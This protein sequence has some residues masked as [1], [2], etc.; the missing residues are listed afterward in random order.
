MQSEWGHFP[1]QLVAGSLLQP[2]R[3]L[4]GRGEAT[5]RPG[6]R[7]APDLEAKGS[8]AHRYPL[9]ASEGHHQTQGGLISPKVASSRARGPWSAFSRLMQP[10]EQDAWTVPG[11]PAQVPALGLAGPQCQ[12]VV[13]TKLGSPD[14][15]LLKLGPRGHQHR[16]ARENSPE[17]RS[18]PRPPAFWLEHKPGMPG[19]HAGRSL[20]W[21]VVRDSHCA[22][23]CPG[24][25]LAQAASRSGR[26]PVRT[27]PSWTQWGKV[28]P[29]LRGMAT[30]PGSWS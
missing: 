22:Q 14:V 25:A 7:S 1:T 18:C 8:A 5:G 26:D 9:T 6:P 11:S 29:S 16:Q 30:K 23:P 10:T 19:P 21:G 13:L 17:K 15:H 4:Q 2:G 24:L 20:A 3:V 12:G 27:T 28:G